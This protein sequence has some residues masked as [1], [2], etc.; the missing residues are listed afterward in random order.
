LGCYDHAHTIAFAGPRECGSNDAGLYSLV[1]L[2][3]QPEA[4]A[5]FG[6]ALY[7]ANPARVAPSGTGKDCRVASRPAGFGTKACADW[8]ESALKT[9]ADEKWRG[10]Y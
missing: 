3:Q 10:I 9:H 6:K 5:K 1:L 7:A 4:G 8:S 2:N